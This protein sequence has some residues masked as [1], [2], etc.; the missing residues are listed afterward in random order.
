MIREGGDNLSQLECPYERKINGCELS[1]ADV[2]ETN[3][4]RS[5]PVVLST[6]FT[7]PFLLLFFIHL[8]QLLEKTQLFFITGLGII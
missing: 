4:T 1:T 3:D 7:C 6:S 5:S 2:G 8:T